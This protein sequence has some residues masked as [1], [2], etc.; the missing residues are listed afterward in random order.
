MMQKHGMS[1]AATGYVSAVFYLALTVPGFWLGRVVCL[2]R[3]FTIPACIIS[4]IA[5]LLII[6]FMPHL[7]AY[8]AGA[9]LVGFGY[10]ALQ[11]IFYDKAAVLAPSSANSTK[12]LSYIMA[13]NYLGVAVCPLF[14]AGLGSELAFVI[15]A[16][17]MGVVLVMSLIFRHWFIF[18]VAN[19]IKAYEEQ[20]ASVTANSS[21][22]S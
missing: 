3:N 9:I 2:F 17:V 5:G 16:G 12:M 4:M 15:S 21:K 20:P 18:N 7:W 22:T 19:E 6:P 10:G 11:P 8:F 13:A 1:D 14:F